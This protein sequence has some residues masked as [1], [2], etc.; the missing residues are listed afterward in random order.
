[1]ST[2]GLPSADEPTVRCLGYFAVGRTT[3]IVGYN[4]DN[5]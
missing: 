4:A 1:M 5:V 3:C 2:F